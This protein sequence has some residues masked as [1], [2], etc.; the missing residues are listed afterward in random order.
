MSVKDRDHPVSVRGNAMFVRNQN[1]RIAA[2]VQYLEKPH[3][4]LRS[5]R[6]EISRRLIRKNDRWIADQRARDGDAAA[7]RRR[8]LLG[9]DSF[10]R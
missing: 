4:F 9:D 6:I 3:D 8:A 1:D 10:G 5:L 2:F 7:D